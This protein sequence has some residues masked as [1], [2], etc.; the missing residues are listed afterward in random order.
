MKLIQRRK[1][2]AATD[3][4][5]L[6]SLSSEPLLISILSCL[7]SQQLL[8]KLRESPYPIFFWFSSHKRQLIGTL[9]PLLSVTAL[10]SLTLT[11]H[12]LHHLLCP[13]PP[14]H[15]IP[16]TIPSFEGGQLLRGR[17][18]TSAT[19]VAHLPARG[20]LSIVYTSNYGH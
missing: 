4:R 5:A 11:P 1:H 8:L 9:T 13:H 7:S 20:R 16:T 14:P 18:I 10:W 19:P 12:F 6:L 15:D 2:V 3:L 17:E